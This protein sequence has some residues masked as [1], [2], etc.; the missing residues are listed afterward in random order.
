M[1]LRYVGA[2]DDTGTAEFLDFAVWGVPSWDVESSTRSPTAHPVPNPTHAPVAEPSPLPTASRGPPGLVDDFESGFDGAVW[3]APCGGCSY[4]YGSLTVSGD[5]QL[6]R[7]VGE[8]SGLTRLSATL[9]KDD[10]CDDHGLVVSSSAATAWVWGSTANTARFVWNCN[11]KYIY[12][13]G[14]SR[15]AACATYRTYA[16]VI[17]LTPTTV[18]FTDDLC[19]TLAL[20]DAVGSQAYLYVFIGA[21]N[22]AGSA[23]WD[24]F[25]AWG[26]PTW[27]DGAATR[28][29]TPQPSVYPTLPGGPAI[30]DDF[31]AFDQGYWL[32]PCVGCSFGGGG[33]TVAGSDM[34]VR[35]YGALTGLGRIKGSL[36]K[37]EA[38]DD[39]LLVVSTNPYFAWSWGSASGSARFVW[40]CNT[41]YIYGGAGSATQPCSAFRTYAVD[42]RLASRPSVGPSAGLLTFSDD[43]CGALALDD[44]MGHT[45]SAGDDSVYVYVGADDDAGS[46]VWTRVQA[47]GALGWDP[48][49][50]HG[51]PTPAPAPNPTPLP[52]VGLPAPRF[53]DD[54]AAFDGALWEAPCAGCSYDGASLAVSGNAQ[55]MRTAG[56][57]AGLSTLRCHLRKDD[58][59][60]D[61]AL[62]VSSAPG[63]AWSWAA[64]LGAA[65][66]ALRDAADSSWRCGAFPHALPD[67]CFLFCERFV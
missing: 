54:F 49:T 43:Y 12:G 40:N 2:D 62:V 9:R 16:V 1:P 57:F 31:A 23:H 58:A 56:A 38:C 60:D 21:D 46:A 13:S 67:M 52:T 28:G 30:D 66:R 3:A 11:A 18:S 32:A 55:L 44:P 34:L 36:V 20:A 4:A 53:F 61:H 29:P 47:W 41:K 15:S 42:V 33:L 63:I 27:G 26:I 51:A 22:D 25:A 50:A 48:A 59:C 37:A 14:A 39:H 5:S 10:A 17:A 8:L 24:A 45:A 19:G 65:K 35:S 7:T 64:T 6:L